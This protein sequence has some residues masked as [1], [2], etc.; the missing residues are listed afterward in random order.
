[1]QVTV[2][3]TPDSGY[4]VDTITVTA[5]DSSNVP[6]TGGKF[7]MPGQ[8]VT[9]T[10]TFKESAGESYIVDFEG[11]GENANRRLGTQAAF[12]RKGA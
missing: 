6:V 9:V 7:T 5:A 1:M 8:A 10:V 4:A 3:A 12:P 11:D 2:N